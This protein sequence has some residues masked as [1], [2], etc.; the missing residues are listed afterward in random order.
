MKK[1]APALA[2]ALVL[3]LVAY[4]N[5]I[6]TWLSGD[7]ITA[8]DLNSALGHIHTTMVGGH[9]PRL[10][11]ADVASGAAISVT[12]LQNGPTVTAR[13]W[14]KLTCTTSCTTSTSFG[15]TWASGNPTTGVTLSFAPSCAS[16]APVAV[17]SSDRSGSV[18]Y[19]SG[20]D[21]AGFIV[22]TCTTQPVNPNIIIFCS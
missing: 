13:A 17:V 19:S 18:C 5:P 2:V 22:F 16:G 3:S 8:A 1:L 21:A 12:K 7:I 15:T 14:A 11:N 20:P 9:G 4:A 6:K 10:T